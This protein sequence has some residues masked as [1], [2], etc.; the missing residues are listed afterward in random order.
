[1]KKRL[2]RCAAALTVALTL[3]MAPTLALADDVE[4]S[5]AAK[6]GT[7]GI[8]VDLDIGIN[9]YLHARIGVGALKWNYGITVDDLKYDF[10]MGLY[11]LGLFLD[12]HPG[13]TGFRLTGGVIFNNHDIS[14]DTTPKA[15]RMYSIGGNEYPGA[16]IGKVEA[17]AKF[18]QFAPYVGFGYGADFG[19]NGHWSF[20]M[21]VGV[22]WWGSPDVDL[23]AANAALVPGLKQDIDDEVAKVEDDLKNFRFYPVLAVGVSYR[24]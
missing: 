3:V 24:F 18:N 12:W 21:D 1:M 7:L 2:L 6:V 10:G 15:D 22:M 4:V 9:E 11:T 16:V 13:G 20:H 5:A 17:E 23:T 14:A 8:G 19:N